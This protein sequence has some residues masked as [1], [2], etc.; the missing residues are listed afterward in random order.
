MT[1]GESIHLF[2]SDKLM[3]QYVGINDPQIPLYTVAEKYILVDQSGRQS[4]Y[5]HKRSML[6]DGS[7]ECRVTDLIQP[8]T[9][10]FPEQIRRP[11]GDVGG[12]RSASP[13][14]LYD[15]ELRFF[16]VMLGRLGGFRCSVCARSCTR[17]A[18]HRA[19][20]MAAA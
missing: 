8:L 6:P 5:P 17:E 12:N 3:E 20:L 15:S 13:E 10:N 18:Q 11:R 7:A 9:Y 16:V 4:C 19:I 2:L 14:P 1:T